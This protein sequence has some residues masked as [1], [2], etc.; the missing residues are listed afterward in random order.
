MVHSEGFLKLVNDAKTRTVAITALSQGSPGLSGDA[1]TSQIYN[2]R[3][4]A[5]LAKAAQVV[6]TDN[7]GGAHI[8]LPGSP[9]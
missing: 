8:V 1:L 2:D 5:L 3:I 6:T 4:G 7:S 9:R